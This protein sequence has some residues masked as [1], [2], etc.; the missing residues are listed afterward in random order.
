M[1]VTIIAYLEPILHYIIIAL[2]VIGLAVWLYWSFVHKHRRNYAI[3]PLF[4]IAHLLLFYIITT[5]NLIS[6][7]I[8]ILWIDLVFLHSI[9]V[10]ISAGIL[11]TQLM[12]RKEE[13]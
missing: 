5:L 1:E 2:G 11:M 3:S 4:Y 9:I 7:Q 6:Q 13:K 8:Y 10:V 12:R